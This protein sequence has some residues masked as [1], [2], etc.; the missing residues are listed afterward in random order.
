M[1]IRLGKFFHVLIIAMFLGLSL[2]A[3]AQ[4]MKSKNSPLGHGKTAVESQQNAKKWAQKSAENYCRL[5]G[6]V[7]VV[8][9]EKFTTRASY[10]KK[11]YTSSVKY[12]VTCN[13]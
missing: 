13:A 10:D 6:G 7:A 5:H 11:V 4:E 9:Y 2:D 8:T 3:V 1:N 12:T